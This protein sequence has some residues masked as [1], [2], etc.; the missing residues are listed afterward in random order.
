MG[1][2]ADL[3]HLAQWY[4]FPLGPRD[5]SRSRH[6]PLCGRRLGLAN[7][8]TRLILS[9]GS[10]YLRFLDPVTLEETGRLPVTHNSKPVPMLNEL[11]M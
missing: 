3:D 6:L 5:F 10:A 7:D 8:G 2:R 9:D 4:R 1:R 11:N